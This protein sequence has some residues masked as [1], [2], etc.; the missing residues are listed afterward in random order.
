MPEGIIST[1]SIFFLWNMIGP[2]LSDCVKFRNK[3][4]SNLTL[5]ATSLVSASLANTWMHKLRKTLLIVLCLSFHNCT[6]DLVSACQLEVVWLCC[7][8]S[9][10]YMQQSNLFGLLIIQPNHLDNP[11]FVRMHWIVMRVLDR[12]KALRWV[13]Q[14]EFYCP[15]YTIC[16]CI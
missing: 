16:M 14:R 5:E 15:Y 11:T 10:L 6:T 12:R 3:S 7:A 2:C 1:S 8:L 4:A 9:F 13:G